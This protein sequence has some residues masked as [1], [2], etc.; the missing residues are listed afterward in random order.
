MCARTELAAALLTLLCAGLASCAV[1]PNFHRPTA[2]SDSHYVYGGDPTATSSAAGVAQRF[3]PGAQVPSDWWK[4]FQSPQLDALVSEALARNPGLQA[5]QASLRASQ[6]ALRSGYGIFW[7]QASADAHA[8]R[9]RYSPLALG[10]SS[11]G[12]IFNLFTLSASVSYVLDVFG[13]ERRSLEA[14]ASQVDVQHATEDATYLTLI[15]NIVNTAVAEAAYRDEIQATQQLIELQR[16]QVQLAQIQYEAGTAPYSNVL[17]LQSQLASYEA[18]VPQLEQKL[19]Q[20][21]DLLATLVGH[22]PAQWSPPAIGFR[23]LRLP[24]DLPV[25]LPS[26]LVRQ[27]PDILL[28]EAS[29]HAASAD[30]GVAT[31]AMLPSLALSGG[32][33][34][35]SVRSSQLFAVNGREWTFGADL[36][37]PL[38]QG[39]TLYYRRREAIDTFAQTMALYRQTVLGAFGQVAD[40]LRALAHDAAALA[41]EDEAL[42]TA[43]QA[44]HLVQTN[45]EA[46]LDTY[47]DVLNADV[48]YHQALIADVQAAAARYQDTVAL[49]VALG[50]G[51]WNGPDAQ[52]RASHGD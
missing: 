3:E 20:S 39:G 29:A 16:Q 35:N 44:L 6:D 37:A 14:L 46:G 43:G 38:F 8:T 10:Q 15:A 22:T 33:S 49:Y 13:G 17:S 23:D 24:R 45:Y 1:G 34:A 4:L 26:D 31:A 12:S 50:G 42:S 7:P 28:A 36:S 51:W 9:Q 18:T 30:I 25:S 32:Y 47:L 21:E 52:T 19:N 41:A 48:Q 5:A 2:P 11:P 40:T 27:R